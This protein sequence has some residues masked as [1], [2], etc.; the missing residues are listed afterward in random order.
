MEETWIWFQHWMERL[1]YSTSSYDS[2]ASTMQAQQN[3]VPHWYFATNSLSK[4]LGKNHQRTTMGHFVGASR[5]FPAHFILSWSLLYTSNELQHPTNK[6]EPILDHPQRGCYDHNQND[7]HFSAGSQVVEFRHSSITS[8]SQLP[9]DVP[10]ERPVWVSIRDPSCEKNAFQ[11]PHVILWNGPRAPFYPCLHL[12]RYLLIEQRTWQ[13][14]QPLTHLLLKIRW[15][16]EVGYRSDQSLFCSA[17]HGIKL[18]FNLSW[19]YPKVFNVALLLGKPLHNLALFLLFTTNPLKDQESC[20]NIQSGSDNTGAEANINSGF[21]T[22]EELSDII[23]LVCIKQIQYNTFFS[24]HQIP[25]EKNVDA[26]DLSR[27]RTS[28]FDPESRAQINLVEFFDPT[29]FPRYIN[30]EVQ[31]GPNIHSNVKKGV[32]SPCDWSLLSQW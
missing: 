19:T 23:K 29:P 1:V 30:A 32:L 28:N 18:N 10:I 2:A 16:L 21:S 9:K 8:K 25:G 13:S 27:G 14:M 3:Q 15:A 17:R 6:M 26:D 20:I 5:S 4:E 12:Y 22:T 31:W 11:T 7:L 24:I